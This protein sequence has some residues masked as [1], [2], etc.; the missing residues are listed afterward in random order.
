[1]APA[2]LG[3]HPHTSACPPP[4]HDR[5]DAQSVPAQHGSPLPPHPPHAAVPHATPLAHATHTLPPPPHA[6]CSVPGSQLETSQQPLHEVP[7]Q[8]QRPVSQ[9]WPLPHEPSWHEPPHPSSAPHALPAQ[10]GTQPQTPVVPPPPHWSGLA[11]PVPAQ[12]GWPLPPHVP[13]STPHVWPL[14]HGA[15]TTPPLPQDE[16]CVPDAHVLPLQ[17]PA[18]DVASHLHTPATHRWP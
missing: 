11:Q 14:A 16:S 6:S 18:H 15:H 3:V 7:S 1:M 13:Q 5:G 17:Q 12:H 4:P 8:M 10:L 2:Q 9:C